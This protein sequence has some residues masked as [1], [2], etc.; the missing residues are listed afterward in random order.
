MK[1][2][3]AWIFG[4]SILS[5]GAV[6]SASGIALS[7]R[8]QSSSSEAEGLAAFETV[9]AVL[10]HPRCQN[11]HIPGDAPLQFDEGRVHGQNV[12]R[13][14][15]GKGSPGLG[16]G[17][18]HFSANPPASYGPHIPPGAPNW[19]L[20]P[21]QRKMVFIRLSSGELCRTIKDKKANGGKDLAALVEHVS[22]DK[23]VLWGWNPGVG[24]DPVSIP[25]AEFVA[26]F[27]QWVEAGAPCPR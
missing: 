7:V 20:P 9:R 10:Q 2:K 18:C 12:R 16:C 3:R 11:C 27:T 25:Q 14:P 13:G 19:H 15:E 24:R 1:T 5:A 21:P 8:A 17:T 23:L 22:H 6:L 26:K 4:W